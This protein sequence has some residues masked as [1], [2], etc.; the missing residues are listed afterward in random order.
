MDVKLVESTLEW[1]FAGVTRDVDLKVTQCPQFAN[2]T[3]DV[4]G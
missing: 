3:G 1:S 2:T 4:V